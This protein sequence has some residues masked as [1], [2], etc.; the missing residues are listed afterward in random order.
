[1]K[2]VSNASDENT[3][4]QE[5][6]RIAAA[7]WADTHA[8]QSSDAAAFGDSVGRVYRAALAS[9]AWT[10]LPREG[11]DTLSLPPQGEPA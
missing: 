1:M 6:A 10:D 3:W 4:P 5:V 8:A 9:A 2:V 7:A 11:A